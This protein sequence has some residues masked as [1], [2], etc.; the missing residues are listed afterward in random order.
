MERLIWISSFLQVA[1]IAQASKQQAEG[2]VVDENNLQRTVASDTGKV[3]AAINGMDNVDADFRSAAKIDSQ[4]QALEEY[5]FDQV[6]TDHRAATHLRLR[7]VKEMLHENRREAAH[8]AIE[9]IEEPGL[10][11]QKLNAAEDAIRKLREEAR[12]R[13]TFS[14][15]SAIPRDYANEGVLTNFSDSSIPLPVVGFYLFAVA[16]TGVLRVFIMRSQKKPLLG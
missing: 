4:A 13:S 9:L 7:A 5:H 8:E 12:A 6:Q 14:L 10:E 15:V 11:N 16:A 3:K 2:R 1:L